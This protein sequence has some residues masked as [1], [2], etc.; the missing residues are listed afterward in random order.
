MKILFKLFVFHFLFFSFLYGASNDTNISK[1]LNKPLMERYIFDE[2]KELRTNHLKLKEELTKQITSS[3]LSISDRALRYTTDTVNNVFYIIAVVS[4]L[5][6]IIGLKS[7]K[8]LKESSELIVETKIAELTKNYE[9]RLSDIERKAKQRF[10]LITKTQEEVEKSQKINS[11]WKRVEIE[12][13]LQE[14]LN[15]YDEILK[16]TPQDVETLVYK[17]DILL[18][19][20]ETRWAL[21]LC[22]QAIKLDDSYALSHWQRACA[23]A[24]L[25]N[26]ESSLEDI[27]EALELNPR[28]HD[29]LYN[30]ESFKVLHKNKVFKELLK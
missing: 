15:L 8:D 27:K 17:A 28:L 19:L 25:G 5:L 12:D 22:N 3:E 1:V 24:K 10:E 2:L 26:V 11:L 30:E 9:S 29:E 20:D 18:D 14:K 23:N 6:L 16:I 13:D 4:S 7:F 21:S